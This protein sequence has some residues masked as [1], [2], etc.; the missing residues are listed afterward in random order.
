MRLTSASKLR[1]SLRSE[2]SGRNETSH[3]LPGLCN[4]L[5]GLKYEKCYD[6][7]KNSIMDFL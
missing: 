7:L 4:E 5:S 3:E 2:Y 1:V 6:V